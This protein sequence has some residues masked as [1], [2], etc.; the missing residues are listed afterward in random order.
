MYITYGNV[1]REV[2]KEHTTHLTLVRGGKVREGN[3]GCPLLLLYT[4]L[5]EAHAIF[6][7]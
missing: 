1:H 2:W 6:E 4:L 5:C 3:G 7:M